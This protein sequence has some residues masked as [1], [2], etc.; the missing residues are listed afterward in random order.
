MKENK[1]N[2]VYISIKKIKKIETTDE[3]HNI[4]NK[5]EQ[6]MKEIIIN[7]SDRLSCQGKRA[8]LKFVSWNINGIRAWLTNHGLN[9]IEKEQPDIICFQ[10]KIPL[11]CN[12]NQC[13]TLGVK[14]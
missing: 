13:L 9:Y 5:I 2:V 3:D 10:V 14:M 8:T 11:K 12:R 6:S 4:E 1:N 7:T